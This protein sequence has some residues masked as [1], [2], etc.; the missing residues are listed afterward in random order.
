MT[1]N[2]AGAA[3]MT[4][5]PSGP[6][7]G[8]MAPGSRYVSGAI[9]RAAG[10]FGAGALCANASNRPRRAV[11]ISATSITAAPRHA[12]VVVY[13]KN[14][15]FMAAPMSASYESLIP[16]FPLFEGFTTH[17]A[18]RLI[19]YGQ[20]KQVPA[21]TTLFNEGETA[22]AV[23]LVLAGDLQVFVRRGDTDVALTS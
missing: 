4:V 2:P 17:G 12:L 10:G 21:G 8:S 22:S 5:L 3:R 9:S 7:S 18:R 15:I 23:V 13:S 19:E 6:R 20:V 14:A 11:R 1:I 16:T